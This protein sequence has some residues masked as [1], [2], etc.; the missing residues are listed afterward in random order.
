MLPPSSPPPIKKTIKQKTNNTGHQKSSGW[1]VP[2]VT[3][4]S[5]IFNFLWMSPVLLD[6]LN[7]V[8]AM[9]MTFF[10]LVYKT[11]RAPAAILG[12]YS[13]VPGVL[14]HSSLMDWTWLFP[15]TWVIALSRDQFHKLETRKKSIR[16]S[17]QNGAGVYYA[18]LHRWVHYGSG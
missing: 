10:K 12:V 17:M 15:M 4:M 2:P 9:N 3:T 8:L 14:Y 5:T 7:Y 13:L 18:F 16:L 1:S 11:P 6:I